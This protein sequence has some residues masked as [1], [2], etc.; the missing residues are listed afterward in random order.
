VDTCVIGSNTGL[1]IADF[2]RPVSV[3]DLAKCKTVSA[4]VTCN[5]N[6]VTN[7]KL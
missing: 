7:Y 2:K 4:I 5:S 6:D 3:G 1:V